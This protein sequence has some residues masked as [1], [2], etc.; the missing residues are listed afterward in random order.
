MPALHCRRLPCSI[1]MIVRWFTWHRWAMHFL[2]LLQVW[3]QKQLAATLSHSRPD[4]LLPWSTSA[5]AFFL[6]LFCF[7]SLLTSLFSLHRLAHS[8]SPSTTSPPHR[9][10]QPAPHTHNKTFLS[11]GWHAAVQPPQ[12]VPLTPSVSLSQPTPC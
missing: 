6:T 10:A 8:S 7:P 11:T 1:W 4:S 9:L 5:S 2:R 3:L 12:Q